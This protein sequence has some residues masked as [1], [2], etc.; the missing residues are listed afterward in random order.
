MAVGATGQVVS[1]ALPILFVKQFLLQ[2][3]LN[4][5]CMPAASSSGS[6]GQVVPAPQARS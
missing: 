6:P 5:G 4:F 2:L 1:A 3:S